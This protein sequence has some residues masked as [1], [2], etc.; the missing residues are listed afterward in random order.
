MDLF[1]WA[2]NLLGKPTIP[3]NI[4]NSQH[5]ENVEEDISRVGVFVVKGKFHFGLNDAQDDLFR[6]S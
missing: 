1:F 2:G 6:S 5:H 4:L 3:T